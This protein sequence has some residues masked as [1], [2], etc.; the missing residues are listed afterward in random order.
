MKLIIALWGIVIASWDTTTGVK[1]YTLQ[2]KTVD[3]WV[4]MHPNRDGTPYL[5]SRTVAGWTFED[6][7]VV[8]GTEV[9]IYKVRK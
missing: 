7:A 3:G 1:G 6:L 4:N 5:M 2:V 9:R 8:K